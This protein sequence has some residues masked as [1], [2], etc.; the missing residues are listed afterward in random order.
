MNIDPTKNC[1]SPECIRCGLCKKACPTDAITYG[2]ISGGV[3]A[4]KS[5]LVEDIKPDKTAET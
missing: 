5:K 4:G 3:K 1:N 2:F